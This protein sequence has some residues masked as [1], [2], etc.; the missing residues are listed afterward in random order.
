MATIKSFEQIEAWQLSR[1]LVKDLY[2][3][4]DEQKL[5]TQ[6]ELM[7][8]IKRAALSIMNNIAE[9][10]GRYSNGDFIRFLDYSSASASE[11]KSMLYV[12]EDLQ[13]IT[14]DDA[15]TYRARIDVIQSKV[16]RLIKYLKEHRSK[17][18]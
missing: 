18:E 17:K 13:F 7:S 6:F 3:I 1:E 5:K 14:R 2:I 15:N 16:L 8:Q 11:V 4:F 10:Y 9:G 12:M